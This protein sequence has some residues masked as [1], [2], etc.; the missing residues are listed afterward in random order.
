MER[1]PHLPNYAELKKARE[2]AEPQQQ[3]E[4]TRPDGVH[5]PGWTH[6][7]GMPAQQP[8]ALEYNKR[9]NE[10]LQNLQERKEEKRSDVVNAPE[11][12]P[13]DDHKAE[14]QQARQQDTKKTAQPENPLEKKAEGQEFDA[15]RFMTDPDYRREMKEQRIAEQ[16]ERTTIRE[17]QQGQERPVFTDRQ[18]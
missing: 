11:K 6:R 14:K 16:R 13:E 12:T 17:R 15:K 18:R 3:H 9:A 8:S 5:S 2:E 1:E 4:P 7:G 10:H